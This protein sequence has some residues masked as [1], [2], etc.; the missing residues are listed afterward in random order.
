[1]R[2]IA[3]PIPNGATSAVFNLVT[4]EQQGTVMMETWIRESTAPADA[5]PRHNWAPAA[6]PGA[7]RRQVTD[8]G[9]YH[10]TR[11]PL[12][13]ALPKLLGRVLA[14]Q[15]RAQVLCGDDERLRALDTA[16]WTCQDP[17]WLPHGSKA[18]ATPPCSRSG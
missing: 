6:L 9:F 15:G 3:F 4:V 11:T 10:L 16:L 5:P 12:D 2:L 18:M 1:M 17:D 8:I 13:Q 14:Q 7:R